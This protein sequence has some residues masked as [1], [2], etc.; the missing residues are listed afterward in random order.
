MVLNQETLFP[1]NLIEFI[2]EE[3][4]FQ[5]DL[6]TVPGGFDQIPKLF[7]P[8]IGNDVHLNTR[9]TN[10]KQT[11]DGVEVRYSVEINNASL[12]NLVTHQA[13][14]SVVACFCFSDY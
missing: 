6:V 7:E 10:I 1:I 3:C 13:Q 8:L 4:I 12:A 9:V 11:N 2:L 14:C 5:Q